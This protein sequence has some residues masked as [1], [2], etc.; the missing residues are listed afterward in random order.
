MSDIDAMVEILKAACDREWQDETPLQVATI[1]ANAIHARD[2]EIR[3]LNDVLASASA[4]VHDV[5][6]MLHAWRANRT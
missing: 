2:L 5:L 6:S 3:R 1:A 4:D